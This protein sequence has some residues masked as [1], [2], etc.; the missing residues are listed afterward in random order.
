MTS[1]DVEFWEIFYGAPQ[2]AELEVTEEK[3]CNT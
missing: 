2:K 3:K 1:E